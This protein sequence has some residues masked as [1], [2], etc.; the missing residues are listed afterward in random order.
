L[1]ILFNFHRCVGN[2]FCVMLPPFTSIAPLR[3]RAFCGCGGSW[4]LPSNLCSNFAPPPF[5]KS[6]RCSQGQDLS[7]S[8]GRPS[9][10]I[11]PNVKNTSENHFQKYGVGLRIGFALSTDHPTTGP[12]DHR[13]TGPPD[14]RTTGPPDHWTTSAVGPRCCLSVR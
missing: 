3:L 7:Q 4:T 5:P 9:A 2:R 14:H 10:S 6:M 1:L 8:Y 12:P 11:P 13:T